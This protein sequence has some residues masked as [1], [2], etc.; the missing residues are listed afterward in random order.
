VGQQVGAVEEEE[1][2]EEEEERLAVLWDRPVW[3]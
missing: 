1:E 3:G 2:E